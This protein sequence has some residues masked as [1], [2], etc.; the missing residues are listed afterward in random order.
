MDDKSSWD[1]APNWDV[2]PEDRVEVLAREFW[3]S[4]GSDSISWQACLEWAA[5]A[6]DRVDKFQPAKT[7]LKT[8]K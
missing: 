6:L 5:Y 4:N 2:A 7:S 8:A 3:I 1:I